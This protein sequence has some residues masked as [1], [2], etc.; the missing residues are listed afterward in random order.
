M[1]TLLIKNTMKYTLDIRVQHYEPL[2]HCYLATMDGKTDLVIG[3]WM[4][5]SGRLPPTYPEPKP[6]EKQRI[7]PLI[8][9]TPVEYKTV[10]DKP[11]GSNGDVYTCETTVRQPSDDGEQTGWLVGTEQDMEHEVA[12]SDGSDVGE[13][14]EADHSAT[15]HIQSD[16]YAQ[17]NIRVRS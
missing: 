17:L 10:E 2:E 5:W 13:C 3:N 1:L 4:L 14:K 12:A 11:L 15:P 8:P 9:L 6:V 7:V 16:P